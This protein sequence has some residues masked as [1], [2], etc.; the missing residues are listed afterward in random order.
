[1]EKELSTAFLLMTH[2]Y[3]CVKMY[4]KERLKIKMEHKLRKQRNE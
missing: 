4:G 1:M 3:F 2:D